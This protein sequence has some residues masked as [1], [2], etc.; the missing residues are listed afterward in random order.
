M[1]ELKAL[2]RKCGLRNYSRLRKAELI[3]LIRNNQ[4]NTNP[5][6]QSWEPNW[7]PQPNRPPPLPPG[8]S[9][10]SETQTWEP[11]DD[12][13]RPELQVPLTKWQLKCRRAR[14]S[15]LAKK[16]VSLNAEINNLK[17]QME[18]LRD[19]IAKAFRSTHSGFKRKK[20]RSMKKEGDKIAKKL[21]ESEAK[22]KLIKARVPKDPIS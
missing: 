9:H 2:A 12:R 21:A 11:I 6:L 5:P 4:W 19:R 18:S 7:P 1:P 15:K 17:F 20:I 22:L 16:F 13:L 3:E 14:D 8:Q 10:T